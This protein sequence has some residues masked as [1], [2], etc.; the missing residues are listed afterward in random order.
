MAYL[1][2]AYDVEEKRVNK[3][4]KLLKRYFMWVQ[5][6]VFEGEISE[7]KLEKCQRELLKLIDEKVDSI[8][9]YRVENKLN[10]KK[11]VL[12]IEKDLTG[13]IL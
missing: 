12:G 3:V 8:Y 2:V 5:N 1:I 7:G 10:Y 13:N 6:S 11:K 9:F 4:R